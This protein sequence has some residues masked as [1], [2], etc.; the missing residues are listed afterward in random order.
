MELLVVIAILAVLAGL[1]LPALRGTR[2]SA[3][4]A[5]ELSAARQLM[6]AYAAYAYDH[7]GALLPGFAPGL[8][9]ENAAG[10]DISGLE[11][12]LVAARY[13]WRLAP[14]LDYDLRG[15]I[16]DRELREQIAQDQTYHENWVSVLPS[17]G[18]NASFI[19]GDFD[20]DGLGSDQLQRVFGRVHL[21]RLSE[22][23]HPARLLVFA[24]ARIDQQT[25]ATIPLP[26][27]REIVEGYHTI[28]PPYLIE[29]VWTPRYQ[30]DGPV[31]SFGYVSLRH[32]HRRAAIGF[33]D[34]HTGTLDEGEIQD[35]RYWSDQADFAAW[36]LQPLP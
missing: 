15:L 10:E 8:P 13:P 35:M 32:H 12:G 28:E 4:K 9:A 21:A 18:I 23:R 7:R 14:W 31:E 3:S 16:A 34:G 25:L 36:T 33:F 30:P 6:L 24:S 11:V 27:G 5:I 2:S 17:L 29:R 20:T 19:G 22:A 26:G 1:L